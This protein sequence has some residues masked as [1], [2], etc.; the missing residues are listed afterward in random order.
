MKMRIRFTASLKSLPNS[1]LVLV[2]LIVPSLNSSAQV[3]TNDL[4]SVKK[5]FVES[6]PTSNRQTQIEP[7][8]TE[9]KRFGFEIVHERS[10]ADAVLSWESQAEIVLH[11]DG[12]VP[13]KSIFTWQLMLSERKSIWKHTVKFVSKKTPAEDLAYGANKLARK[14]F[15]DKERALKKH[16]KKSHDVQKRLERPRHGPTSLLRCEGEPLKAQRL[17]SSLNEH[18]GETIATCVF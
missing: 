5:V 18:C 3:S 11:G 4:A 12:S 16:L 15:E 13:D 6:Y 8:E 10:Q 7:V 9:L 2:F 17:A 14:L 1:W